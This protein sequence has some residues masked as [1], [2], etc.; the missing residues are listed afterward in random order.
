MNIVNEDITAYMD[1]YYSPL[2]G[3]LA[4]IRAY[5]EK[6]LIPIILPDTEMLILSLLKLIKP[7]N[8]LEIGTAIGYSALVMATAAPEAKIVT[9]DN[10]I[11]G[12][13]KTRQEAETMGM[14]HRIRVVHGDGVKL[15]EGPDPQVVPDDGSSYDF[16]FIDAGK[17]HYREFWDGARSLSSKG[18]VILCDNVFMKA[19]VADDR[20]DEEGDFRTSTRRMRDFIDYMMGFSG[21]H[22]SLLPVGDGVSIS[23]VE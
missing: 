20:Y 3:E 11:R 21:I 18:T 16:V 14:S 15:L 5:G 17:S 12:V 10:D 8:I 1:K 22:T 19:M 9:V 4:R 2:N 7:R 6:R 13:V 23:Y